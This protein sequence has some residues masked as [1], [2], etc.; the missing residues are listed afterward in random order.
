MHFTLL[1]KNW[2]VVHRNITQTQKCLDRHDAGKQISWV[3]RGTVHFW[4]CHNKSNVVASS[5]VAV[6]SASPSGVL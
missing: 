5:S 1:G 2:Q 4:T 3:A 6:Y